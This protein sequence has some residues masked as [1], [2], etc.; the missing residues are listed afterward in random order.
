MTDDAD[1][2]NRELM[3]TTTP[4]HRKTRTSTNAWEADADDYAVV[5]EGVVPQTDRRH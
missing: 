2:A 1:P 3:K 4:A 5:L